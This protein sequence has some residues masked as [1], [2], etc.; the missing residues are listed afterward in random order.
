MLKALQKIHL[1]LKA[2]QKIHPMIKA[3]Q[4]I[5]LMRDEFSVMLL[6]YE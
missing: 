4:K 1:M 3:L 2:L 5:I 6:A